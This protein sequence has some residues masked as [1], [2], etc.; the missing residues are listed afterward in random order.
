MPWKQ[1]K[2]SF[3]WFGEFLPIGKIFFRTIWR[4]P[5][6]QQFLP[7]DEKYRA[8]K[9]GFTQFVADNVGHNTGALNALG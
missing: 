8:V 1:W 5:P 6:T 9:D 4:I 3:T 2:I 7:I